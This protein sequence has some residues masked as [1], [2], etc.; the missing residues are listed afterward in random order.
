MRKL[1]VFNNFRGE[2]VPLLVGILV[3]PGHVVVGICEVTVQANNSSRK[4]SDE[5]VQ[6]CSLSQPQVDQ[7]TGRCPYRVLV[8]SADQHFVRCTP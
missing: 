2:L 8:I 3:G 6:S 1:L 7:E 5:V 4:V